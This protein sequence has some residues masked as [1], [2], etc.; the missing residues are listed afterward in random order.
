MRWQWVGCQEEDET[1]NEA[2]TGTGFYFISNRK[3]IKGL[4]PLP[5]SEFNVWTKKWKEITIY[6]HGQ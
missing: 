2:R 3:S 5:C 1:R 4:G 6:V